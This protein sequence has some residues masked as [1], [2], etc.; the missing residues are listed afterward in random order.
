M[1]KQ[2]IHEIINGL[3]HTATCDGYMRAERGG[4]CGNAAGVWE[5][6]AAERVRTHRW[7][8]RTAKRWPHYSG[9]RCYPVPGDS[10]GVSANEAFYTTGFSRWDETTE[11]GRLRWDLLRFLLLEAIKELERAR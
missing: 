10:L 8:E 3:V 5:V 2:H 6:S 1:K 7:I 4:I 9:E 11:Y